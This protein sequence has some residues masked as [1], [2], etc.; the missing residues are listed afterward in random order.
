MKKVILI[1]LDGYGV[2]NNQIGN[3]IYDVNPSNIN[4]YKE[5]FPYTTLKASG[6]A[7]GLPKNEVGNSEVGHINIGAGRVV[8]QDLPR[9]NNSIND[10]SFYNSFSLKKTI[11]H[12][13]K[14]NGNIHILGLVSQGNVHS[15]LNHLYALL[16]F[17]KKNNFKNVFLHLFTDGRDSPPKSGIETI[18]NL[19]E[20]IMQIGVG[21]IASIMGRYFAMDRDNRWERTQKAYE[22]LTEGKDNKTETVIEAIQKSY[23]AG[24][25][26]EF[27][28]PVNILDKDENISLIKN[29]DAV[30]F[31]NFRID[32]PRQLTKAFVLGKFKIKLSD[33]FFVTM[34]EY[35]AGLPVEI[36]FPT[37]RVNPNVGKLI[38]GSNLKQ[39]RLTE[40]EKERFVTYYFNG[41][42]ETAYKNEIRAI[43]PSPKVATYD[44]KP[45]MSAFEITQELIKEITA[46][47]FDFILVNFA[48]ADMVGHT[49][50]IEACKLAIK[51]L[52]ECIGKIS[53][54]TL[55]NNYSLIITADHGNIEQK[56]NPLTNQVSTEHT[57][58]PVPFM[59]IDKDFKNKK[60]KLKS[61]KLADVGTTILALLDIK[62]PQTMTGENLLK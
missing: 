5:N 32:R 54:S 22:C 50:D 31:F 55:E 18:K 6:E 42:N 46:N 38:S 44:K 7:V 48:N 58:N 41:Q 57:D 37:I 14:T 13:S 15:S 20:K 4:F 11:K 33:L 51:T 29:G 26:D 34:T 60:L 2:S 8:L 56:I 59:F 1:V 25:T 16:E 12:I 35:E 53:K 52:D 3:P 39:L 62:I 36:I 49:G 47:N 28:E 40:S 43:I 9:I 21:K 61:G 19:E 45:E 24:I 27:I 17:Y 23:A 10:L 30:V